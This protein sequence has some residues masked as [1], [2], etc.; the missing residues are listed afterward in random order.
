[1]SERTRKPW[2]SQQSYVRNKEEQ[3]WE[4]RCIWIRNVWAQNQSRENGLISQLEVEITSSEQNIQT[5][6]EMTGKYPKRILLNAIEWYK[7]STAF[8]RIYTR[9]HRTVICVCM[10]TYYYMISLKITWNTLEIFLG[11]W[12]Y[13]LVCLFHSETERY[14]HRCVHNNEVSRTSPNNVL[15][16]W[17][18]VQS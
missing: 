4:L 8:V 3:I 17:L 10:Y 1:M 5:L 12:Q 13:Q 11:F 14:F 2:M 18:L 9:V 16:Y 15:Q 6:P 7:S